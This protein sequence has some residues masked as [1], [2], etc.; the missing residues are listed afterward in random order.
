MVWATTAADNGARFATVNVR[1]SGGNGGSAS[2][3]L[4][5]SN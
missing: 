2:L 5:V 1:D 3:M 4:N